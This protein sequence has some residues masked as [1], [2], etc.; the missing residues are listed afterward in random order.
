MEQLSDSL[1]VALL[2]REVGFIPSQHLDVCLC[3]ADMSWR[4]IWLSFFNLL[5]F[6][7]ILGIDWLSQYY[8]YINYFSQTISF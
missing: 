6:D 7:I 4:L 5:G 2:K 1:G 3:Y 8:A